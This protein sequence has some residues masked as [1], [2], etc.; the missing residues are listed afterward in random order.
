MSVELCDTHCHLDME[1]LRSYLP[2]VLNVSAEHGIKRFIVPAVAAENWSHV[3]SLAQDHPQIFYGLGLH[4]A[5]IGQHSVEDLPKLADKL[6]QLRHQCVALGEIGLDRRYP[7]DAFQE[8]LFVRQ[9]ELAKEVSL[10]VIIHSVG[11]HSK[12]LD[13]LQTVP[14]I[15]G[16]IHAF[17]GSKEQAKQFVDLGFYLGAGSLVLRSAKTREAFQ[18]VS[19][20]SILLE[21][22]S[23]DMYLPTSSSRCGTPV[24][25]RTVLHELA[26]LKSLDVDQAARAFQEN[27]EKL[28]FLGK[29]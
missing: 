2:F 27:C 5:F 13:L 21:T 6:S 14:D 3:E 8:E 9:L 16:V 12:V 26:V 10:P 11:R 4:P 20:G 24:D 18:E 17:S 15:R 25:L 29:T 28:F 1:P 22:D 23:P 19:I 7:D